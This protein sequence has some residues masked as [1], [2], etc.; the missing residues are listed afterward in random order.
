MSVQ[1][2]S[3]PGR[4]YGGVSAAERVAVRHER[5][6]E[7]GLELFGTRGYVETGVKDIC[8]EAGLTDRYFYESFDDTRGLFLAVFDR[9]TDDLFASVSTSVAE[10]GPEPEPEL[11]A[12]IAGFVGALAED[13][14]RAR[15]VFSEGPAAGPEA[16]RHMRATLRRFRGLVAATARRH[17]GPAVEDELVELVALSV[18]GSLERTIAEWQDGRLDLPLERIVDELTRIFRLMLTGLDAEA[19]GGRRFSRRGPG[20]AGAP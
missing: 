19:T 12:G 8:S 5:L 6:L 10:A 1:R 7:A 18:V 13:P 20:P 11:R 15:V 2:Q 3:A 16:E 4:P 14:R 9:V 17:L